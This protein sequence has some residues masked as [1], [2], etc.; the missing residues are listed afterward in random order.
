[1]N[2]SLDKYIIFGHLLR[3]LSLLSQISEENSNRQNSNTKIVTK[4]LNVSQ[5]ID[6]IL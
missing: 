3:V 5:N 4:A 6:N 1:M 2:A